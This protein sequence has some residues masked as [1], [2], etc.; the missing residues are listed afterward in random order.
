M[1]KDTVSEHS[2]SDKIGRES[3]YK[4]GIYRRIYTFQISTFEV[5]P[6]FL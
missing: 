1:E 4:E 6:R 2:P 3:L 5:R